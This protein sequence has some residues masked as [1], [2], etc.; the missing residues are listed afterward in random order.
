MKAIVISLVIFF[1]GY[2]CKGPIVKKPFTM[3]MIAKIALQGYSPVSYID[4]GLAQKGKV[5]FVSTYKEVKYYFTDAKQKS[6]F[7]AD[8]NKYL[9]EYGGY[10][11]FG[12]YAGAKFRP[13]PNKFL[14]KDGKL[15]LFL[16]NLELDAKQLWLAEKDDSK[17]I[18][19]AG[20][21]WAKLKNKL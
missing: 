3:L 12:V 14:T 18:K 21:N 10:C 4:L 9:P 19:T 16:Y 7:D 11:A 20:A 13:D 17:L 2:P 1:V 15:Y 5:Q 6:K 8:P